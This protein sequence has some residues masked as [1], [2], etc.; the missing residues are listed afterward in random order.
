MTMQNAPRKRSGPCEDVI[1]PA[2]LARTAYEDRYLGMY[3]EVY[4]PGGRAVSGEAVFELEGWSNTIQVLY[5]RDGLLRKALLAMSMRTL[6]RL[7]GEIWM[8]E[9]GLNFYIAALQDM[10]VA[11]S[12]PS[13]TR[14]ADALLTA[15]K[16]F[17]HYEVC[18][19]SFQYSMRSGLI[20]CF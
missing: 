6:G 14:R 20:F 16:L 18:F 7:N 13:K 19:V 17:S 2:T 9:E 4:L 3:W 10:S 15:S 1:L 11:L 5:P 8:Q 12:V